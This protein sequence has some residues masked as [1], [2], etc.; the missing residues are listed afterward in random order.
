MVYC[1]GGIICIAKSFFGNFKEVGML[2]KILKVLA[3]IIVVL[4][5]GA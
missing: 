2:K 1:S 4:A 5:L 3:V